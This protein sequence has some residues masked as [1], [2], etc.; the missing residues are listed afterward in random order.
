MEHPDA[1]LFRLTNRYAIKTF[2][3]NCPLRSRKVFLVS[4]SAA[5]G[6][7]LPVLSVTRDTIVCSPAVAS[8]QSY[9]KNFQEYLEF[10]AESKAAGCH[11]PS[12]IFT[13]TD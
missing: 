4:C 5:V 8:F 3:G 9:V 11:M 1:F 7:T 12:S 6:C 10:V 13:S 2:R